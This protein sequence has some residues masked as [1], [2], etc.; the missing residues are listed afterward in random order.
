MWH[1]ISQYWRDGIEILVLA[2]LIYQIYRA[3]RAT[4][5][6]QILVG[7]G[8]ILV[9]LALVTQIFQFEVIGWLI[10]RSAAVL[11]FA[12]L[13]IFQPELRNALARLGS[14]RFFSFSSTRRLAFV[15]RLADSVVL[16]SKKRIGALFA[17]Q[18]D[19][20]LKEQLETGVEL[21][22]R[23]TPELAMS[24]FFPKS[25]LHDGGMIIADDRVAGAACVF[26]VTEKEMQDRS[27]GLRHRAA[28]GLTERTDAVAIVV[29]EETGSISISENGSLHRN[30]TEKQ[31]RERISEIFFDGP[32][33]NETET[34]EKLDRENSV[35][36][37]SDRDM[38]SD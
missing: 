5:G 29:S 32:S 15:E 17:I 22:A 16:L 34:I 37:S 10:T 12:L 4:R 21:D 14:S 20:S 13:V 8:L 18:R 33:S 31:F 19:I 9:L 26:P 38:V 1:F 6:A 24:V 3:F 35:S 30:L 25:P 23:F 28:I 27:T 11:A 36:S 2:T 7:L